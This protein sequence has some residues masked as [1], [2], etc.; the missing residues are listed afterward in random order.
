M[1]PGMPQAETL[2]VVWD[3]APT[4]P[5]CALRDFFTWQSPFQ[6]LQV[7]ST[8]PSTESHGL[9]LHLNPK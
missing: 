2:A 8:P 1:C 6:P 5:G 3:A 9:R 4:T 7:L